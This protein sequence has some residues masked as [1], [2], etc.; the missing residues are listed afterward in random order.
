MKK[1]EPVY[2]AEQGEGDYDG[3]LSKARKLE[4]Q[5]R[6]KTNPDDG[7][8]EVHVTY[9]IRAET[10]FIQGFGDRYDLIDWKK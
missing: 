2:E 9:V 7:I 3:T 8:E 1:S 10:G 5:V 4:Q 6:F